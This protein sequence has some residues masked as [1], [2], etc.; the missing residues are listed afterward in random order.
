MTPRHSVVLWLETICH[1]GFQA[2]N[3]VF[4]KG[5]MA[6]MVVFIAIVLASFMYDFA[7]ERTNELVQDRAKEKK[8]F[9]EMMAM[10]PGM[11]LYTLVVGPHGCGKTWLALELAREM[12]ESKEGGLLYFDFGDSVVNYEEAVLREFDKKFMELSILKILSWL[13]KDKDV[14]MPSKAGF[15]RFMRY[16]IGPHAFDYAK[17]KKRQVIVI[18]DNI[19]SILYQKDGVQ[20]LKDLQRHAK[21]I[22]DRS[23]I[24]MIFIDSGGSVRSIFESQS[25][26]SRMR[27]YE[28]GDVSREEAIQLLESQKIFCVNT[29]TL[30]DTVTGGRLQLLWAAVSCLNH[31]KK[32]EGQSPMDMVFDCIRR[33]KSLANLCNITRE[34][35]LEI[36]GKILNGTELKVEDVPSRFDNQLNCL[37]AKDVLYETYRG[38]VQ[39]Y[40]AIARTQGAK[41]LTTA[42]SREE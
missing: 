26:Q 12:L 22:V 24:H 28:V 6:L 39:F 7:S 14:E 23:Q 9:R 34:F 33:R 11:Q 42:H 21:S 16:V 32:D 5:G 30:Y 15:V 25:A 38:Y 40:S 36:F 1:Y 10:P 4:V 35:I 27:V 2:V 29:T 3:W 37:V 17:R 31:S 20:Q 19:N 13:G 18:V 41:E 8:Q